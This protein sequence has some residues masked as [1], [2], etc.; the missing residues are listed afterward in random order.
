LDCTA[1]LGKSTSIVFAG[2]LFPSPDFHIDN[3]F[4]MPSARSLEHLITF[5]KHGKNDLR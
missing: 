3:P 5:G 4:S 2:Q 1:Q